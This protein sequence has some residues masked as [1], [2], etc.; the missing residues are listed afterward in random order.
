MTSLSQ[1]CDKILDPARPFCR[2]AVVGDA[3]TG[4]SALLQK[5]S[6]RCRDEDML[7]LHIVAPRFNTAKEPVL[8]D[9]DA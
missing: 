1:H 9:I 8:A 6:Q 5:V 3:G 7:T 4:K 2:Y